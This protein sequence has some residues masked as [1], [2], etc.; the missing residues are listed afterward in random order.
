MK[1]FRRIF[2]FQCPASSEGEANG[3]Y[4]PD[5]TEIHERRRQQIGLAKELYERRQ[6]EARLDGILHEFE[7]LADPRL[8]R[9]LRGH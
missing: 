9:R 3:C 6:L 2:T 7:A 5:S 8:I 4:G 1:W